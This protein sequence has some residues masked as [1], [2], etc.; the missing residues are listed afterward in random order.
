MLETTNIQKPFCVLEGSQNNQ[1]F[2]A[3][4]YN[5]RNIFNSTKFRV[6]AMLYI[7]FNCYL[8]E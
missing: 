3:E 5:R 2:W 6:E 4:R 1:G 8:E 7:I